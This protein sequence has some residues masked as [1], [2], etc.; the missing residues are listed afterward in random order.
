MDKIL[1]KTVGFS[2]ESSKVE[3]I[4][5]EVLKQSDFTDPKELIASAWA[6]C[7]LGSAKFVLKQKHLSNNIKSK[8][9]VVTK[10]SKESKTI[11]FEV[12]GN[13]SIENMNALIE[14]GYEDFIKTTSSGIQLDTS[15]I[16][17][18]Y[19]DSIS[20][21]TEL[22]NQQ[23]LLNEQK[24]VERKLRIAKLKLDIEALKFAGVLTQAQQESLYALEE[25]LSLEE[26]LA[27]RKSVV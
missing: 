14:A 21:G 3:V 7:L 18:F 19:L 2:S 22:L 6:V 25:E 27:D 11:Y 12:T 24:E 26:S 13:L 4:T 8:V 10:L 1:A 9:E 20:N 16:M 23:I 17:S 15:G 5:N